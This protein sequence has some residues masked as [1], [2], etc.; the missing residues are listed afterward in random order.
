M[1]EALVLALLVAASTAVAEAV[2]HWGYDN[3]TIPVV[4]T[5]ILA[6]AKSCFT[7]F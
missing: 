1:S 3:L 6:F 5:A 7:F 4:A 2:T